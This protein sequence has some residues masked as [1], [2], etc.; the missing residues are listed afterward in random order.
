M[1]RERHLF[2]FHAVQIASAA[3]AEA[4]YHDERRKWWET[5]QE[6]AIAEVKATTSL[7]VKEFEITG[8]KRIDLSINYGDGA[9]YRRM[10]ESGEKIATHREAAERFET[11]AR[12]YGTQ[13]DRIYE[14]ET[15]DVHYYRLGGG[16]R[17]D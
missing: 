11:D 7:E 6:L 14:L 17:V 9:A 1:S 5:E 4:A 16:P 3:R 8:G 2:Q 10:K 15:A 12:V 13:G